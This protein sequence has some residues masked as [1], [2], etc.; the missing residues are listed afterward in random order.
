MRKLEMD[1]KLDQKL[2]L[3][4]TLKLKRKLK[5]K[6]THAPSK[7]NVGGGSCR[8]WAKANPRV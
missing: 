3:T 5:L 8:W 6:R 1:Q 2:K 4:L 7:S